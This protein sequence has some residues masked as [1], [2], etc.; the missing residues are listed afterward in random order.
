MLRK[1]DATMKLNKTD[2]KAEIDALSL[3]LGEAQR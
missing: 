1:T 3:R 2:Y